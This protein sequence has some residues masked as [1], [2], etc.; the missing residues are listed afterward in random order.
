MNLV[1]NARDAMPQGG[2]ITLRAADVTIDESPLTPEEAPPCGAY[3]ALTVADTG[4]GVPPDL[5]GRI[6]DPFFT[7]KPEGKGTGLGLAMVYGFVKQSNG[8]VYVDSTVDK[9]TTFTLYFPC[10]SGRPGE[11]AGA[12]A[13]RVGIGTETILLV[14]DEEEPR[15]VLARMLSACGYRVLVACGAEEALSIA[16]EHP[17]CIDL[18]VTD[19]VM[20]D[21]SG[22][23]I[24]AALRQGRP[25]VRVLYVSGHAD[26]TV[27]G[28]GG[29]KKADALL[30]KPFDLPA[31][32][33]KVRDALDS[34][35]VPAGHEMTPVETPVESAA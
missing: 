3:V 31:L 28:H 9:G 20:P 23:E 7:T 16:A 19:V 32:S 26:E 5:L 35:A 27:F 15:E 11:D 22:P 34:A 2:R 18:L 25:R 14:E 8:Y 30:R 29:G 13:G 1:V 24:V 33:A 17:S 10:A 21:M 6:F 4:A 12:A